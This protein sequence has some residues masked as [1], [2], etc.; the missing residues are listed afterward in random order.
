MNAT[1]NGAAN[2]ASRTGTRS[3][4]MNATNKRSRM[5]LSVDAELRELLSQAGRQC[6]ERTASKTIRWALKK[7]V[8][9]VPAVTIGMKIVRWAACL[10]FMSP[11]ETREMK[12]LVADVYRELTAGDC[13]DDP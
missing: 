9:P 5:S 6:G 7:A 2:G 8:A 3:C 11:R 4:A 1:N 13:N 12:I 10:K